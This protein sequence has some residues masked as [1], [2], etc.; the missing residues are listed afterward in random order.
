MHY[1]KNMFKPTSFSTNPTLIWLNKANKTDRLWR[2]SSHLPNTSTLCPPNIGLLH[3]YRWWLMP[4]G[5]EGE[6][7]LDPSL[8]PSLPPSPIGWA[9]D[10]DQ[11]IRVPHAPGHHDW[12]WYESATHQ[13]ISPP[14]GA[15]LELFTTIT[16]ARDASALPKAGSRAVRWRKAEMINNVIWIQVYTVMPDANLTL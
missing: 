1:L 12:L 9:S 10:P 3:S 7:E 8:L 2:F 4:C 6:V 14:L 16:K 13:P 15:L 5:K 11:P